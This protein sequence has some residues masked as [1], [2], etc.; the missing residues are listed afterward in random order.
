MLA[1]SSRCHKHGE[2]PLTHVVLK[3][4]HASE[5]PALAPLALRHS[6]VARFGSSF[7]LNI[8]CLGKRGV[9][10]TG[11]TLLLTQ[12]LHDKNREIRKTFLRKKHLSAVLPYLRQRLNHKPCVRMIRETPQNKVL[13]RA[14]LKKREKAKTQPKKV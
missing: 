13:C 5:P 10:E 9:L 3:P 4:F 14:M 2:H 11:L 6:S 12:T 8:D 7:K 1:M